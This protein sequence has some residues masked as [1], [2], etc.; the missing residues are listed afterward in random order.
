MFVLSDWYTDL[1]DVYR[2]AYTGGAVTRQELMLLYTAVP[3]RVYSSQQNNLAINPTA[4]TA[5]KNDKLACAVDTDIKAGDVLMVTR[6][7]ALNRGIS[8]VRYIASQPQAFF[9]PVGGA[10]TGLEHLE[11]GLKEDNIIAD[12]IPQTTS[13]T[14]SKVSSG[15]AI[16]ITAVQKI[17]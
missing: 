2:V 10:L 13:T 7:G 11:V 8:P 5:N 16:G 14:G 12:S 9:D 1:M 15:G 6:G 4:A 3:C 17:E